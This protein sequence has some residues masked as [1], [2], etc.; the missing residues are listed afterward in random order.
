MLQAH[1]PE[2]TYGTVIHCFVRAEQEVGE[3]ALNSN[4]LKVLGHEQRKT[5]SDETID[6]G[7]RTHETFQHL[8]VKSSTYV[9]QAVPVLRTAKVSFPD[10]GQPQDNARSRIWNTFARN[11]EERR[12]SSLHAR[13]AAREFLLRRPDA[14]VGRKVVTC[15]LK[16]SVVLSEG[17]EV[18]RIKQCMRGPT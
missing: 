12:V 6:F 17:D 1:V 3:R 9:L 4:K 11:L 18:V 13:L 2:L 14:R 10:R 16:S 8:G 7:S 15:Y 5:M